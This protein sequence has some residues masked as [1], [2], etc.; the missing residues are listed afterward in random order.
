MTC[1][2]WECGV[3]V[4]VPEAAGPA[5]TETNSTLRIFKGT[6]PVPME[7]PGRQYGPTDQP[8]FYRS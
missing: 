4:R 6:V 5:G 8:W 2:N 7:C 3:I 1:R